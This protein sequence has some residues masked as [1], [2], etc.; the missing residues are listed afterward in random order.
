MCV[1]DKSCVMRFFLRCIILPLRYSDWSKK[2]ID[3]L[4]VSGSWKHLSEDVREL[5]MSRDQMNA[6]RLKFCHLFTFG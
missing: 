5:L 4:P 3:G 2:L 6:N 1:S